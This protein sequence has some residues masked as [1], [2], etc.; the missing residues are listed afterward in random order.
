M[1]RE[2]ARKWIVDERLSTVGEEQ[3]LL[4]DARKGLAPARTILAQQTSLVYL[5]ADHC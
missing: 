1:S 2:D 5:I 3:S 4:L